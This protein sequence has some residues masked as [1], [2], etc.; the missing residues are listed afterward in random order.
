MNSVIKINGATFSDT[1]IPAEPDLIVCG[2]T[3]RENDATAHYVAGLSESRSSTDITGNENH[4]VSDGV[5][6]AY[7][8][9]SLIVDVNSSLDT[10]LVIGEEITLIAGFRM[11]ATSQG[12][13]VGSI[14]TSAPAFPSNRRDRDGNDFPGGATL[15]INNGNVLATASYQPLGSAGGGLTAQ[16]AIPPGDYVFAAYTV[17]AA[18]TFLYVPAFSDS[19][20][21]SV[22]GG[23]PEVTTGR[24]IHIGSYDQN[25]L[26]G[27]VEVAEVIIYD[28]F[29]SLE[30]MRQIYARSQFRMEQRGITI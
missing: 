29:V 4:F 11:D 18:S 20:L 2:G 28:R 22:N 7:S 30:E 8:D 23:N 6:A 1:L 5:A 21:P 27:S 9:T 17:S 26:T 15:N 19:A 16:A 24:T 10:G 3:G 25:L 12:Q 14:G 13:V